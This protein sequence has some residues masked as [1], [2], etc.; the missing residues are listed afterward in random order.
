[1]DAKWLAEIRPQPTSAKRMR[2]SPIDLE[3][4]GTSCFIPGVSCDQLPII[5]ETDRLHT[6]PAHSSQLR[7]K[8]T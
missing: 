5:S 6:S 8:G 1:M 2:R 4:A 3:V 7:E